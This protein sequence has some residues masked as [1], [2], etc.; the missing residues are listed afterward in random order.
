MKNTYNIEKKSS[1]K[2]IISQK[3]E[4]KTL[5]RC[6]KIIAIRIILILICIFILL[7]ELCITNSK[8]IYYLFILPMAVIFIEAI[9][10]II[11]RKGNDFRWYLFLISIFL[12]K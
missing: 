2:C 12:I 6:I 8:Q 5:Y 1:F 11:R 7:F 9:Y 3:T 10:I 4:L